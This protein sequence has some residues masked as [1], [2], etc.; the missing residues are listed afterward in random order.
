MKHQQELTVMHDSRI[1]RSYQRIH[2]I[3]ERSGEYIIARVCGGANVM[4]VYLL[5]QTVVSNLIAQSR[6][7]LTTDYGREHS[8]FFI[9]YIGLHLVVIVHRFYLITRDHRCF[10]IAYINYVHFLIV[11]GY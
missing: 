8:I 1:R 4:F 9:F 7:N 5:T 11:L 6:I 2:N 3:A 10:S